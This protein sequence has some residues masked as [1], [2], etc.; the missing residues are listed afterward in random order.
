MIN[1]E[2]FKKKFTCD[3]SEENSFAWIF[4]TQGIR[5]KL[6][7]MK[8]ITEL[9]LNKFPEQ[10]FTENDTEKVKEFLHMYPAKYYAIRDKSKAGGVFKLKIVAED[11]LNE[12]GD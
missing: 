4:S 11:V 6:E 2:E 7:S 8:K 9:K 12:I 3:D 5:N 1:W 10:L